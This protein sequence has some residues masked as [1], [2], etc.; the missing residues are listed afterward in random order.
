MSYLKH[1]DLKALLR[2]GQTI[3]ECDQVIEVQNRTVEKHLYSVYNKCGVNNHSS[4]AYL[5]ILQDRLFALDSLS[6]L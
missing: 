2:I 1:Q 3:L 5:L 6:T 4:L